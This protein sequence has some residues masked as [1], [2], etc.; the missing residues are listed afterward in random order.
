VK[1]ESA[2]VRTRRLATV[3]LFC[4][5]ATLRAGELTLNWWTIDAGG[6]T[7]TGGTL[8]LSGTT[9][10]P[11]AGVL[12]GA[13]LTLSGGFWPAAPNVR[14]GDVNCDGVVDFRD[15]NPFVLIL[16][17]LAGWQAAYP[18]CPW[19]NG[20]CNQDGTVDFKDINPF[21]A[22]LSGG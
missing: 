5:V 6:G 7:A 12:A 17:N 14:P 21:V 11:D 19:Q 4:T 3:L 8:Q 16:S 9:G 22:V 18:G 2:K 20:D 10:Q 1:Y 13:N 15:I